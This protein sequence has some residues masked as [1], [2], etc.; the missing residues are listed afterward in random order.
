MGADDFLAR[1]KTSQAIRKN[2]FLQSR[3]R[4]KSTKA[5][6]THNCLSSSNREICHQSYK[7]CSRH[8]FRSKYGVSLSHLENFS[9]SDDV[10]KRLACSIP[11]Q[12]LKDENPFEPVPVSEIFQ[13]AHSSYINSNLKYKRNFPSTDY[14]SFEPLP[15][16]Y[17]G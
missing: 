5:S 11:S 16:N 14:E 7:S 8:D 12:L 9:D 2:I 13:T 1:D 10:L 4:N 15:I 3:S 17:F 6:N